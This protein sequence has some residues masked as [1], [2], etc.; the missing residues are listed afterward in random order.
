MKCRIW[1]ENKNFDDMGT[2]TACV[3]CRFFPLSCASVISCIA[4]LIIVFF[5]NYKNTTL[6]YK[7]HFD[8]PLWYSLSAVLID[9]SVIQLKPHTPTKVKF[10]RNIFYLWSFDC[11]PSLVVP[12][13]HLCGFTRMLDVIVCSSHTFW[14]DERISS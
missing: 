11:L 8:R 4:T 14:I 13:F 5:F 3:H 2:L 6:G 9:N 7:F 10:R 12:G 1:W